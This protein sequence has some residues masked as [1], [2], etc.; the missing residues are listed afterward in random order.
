MTYLILGVTAW[1]VVHLFPVLAPKTRQR[2]IA[3]IGENPYKGLFALLILLSVAA[4]IYGWRHSAVEPLYLPPASLRPVGIVLVAAGFV[5]MGAAQYPTR[6]RRA[7]RHPQ[8]SGFAL[9]ALA[10]LLTNG[11]SRSLLLFG[12]LATWALLEIILISRRDRVYS[13]PEAPGPVRELVG[14]GASLLVFALFVWL[15][16]YIAGVPL[17][18]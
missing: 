1:S 7:I 13:K 9:W 15:H 16:K 18:R 10:H 11:D 5:L 4:M 12:G 8:L 14:L 2:L 17:L 3:G 6:I